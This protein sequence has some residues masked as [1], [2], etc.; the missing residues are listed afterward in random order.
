LFLISLRTFAGLVYSMKHLLVG[1]GEHEFVDHSS[2]YQPDSLIEQFRE[3]CDIRG[4]TSTTSRY[5]CSFVQLF[6]G[7]L[8]ESGINILEMD[9]G[10]LKRYLSHLRTKGKL[11]QASKSP[12]FIRERNQAYVQVKI[13]GHNL[14]GSAQ[15]D[16]SR[17][18]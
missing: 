13:D 6:A 5:Y 9:K 11:K 7:F 16:K 18:C 3:D 12:I 2:Q 15:R 10:I 8:K 4:L 14:Q 1:S 17:T